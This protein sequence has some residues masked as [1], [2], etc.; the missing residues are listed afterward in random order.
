MTRFDRWTVNLDKTVM[1]KTHTNELF[2]RQEASDFFQ[3]RALTKPSE[4]GI[5][6]DQLSPTVNFRIWKMKAKQNIIGPHVRAIR[7]QQKL[8]QGE[9]AARCGTLGWDASENTIAKIE[10]GVRCV[11]D[12]ELVNLAKALRTKLK[13]LLPGYERLF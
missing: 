5:S 10:S 9:L 4:I 8:T 6:R 7:L 11:T 12:E 1:D 3:S 2:L 13:G